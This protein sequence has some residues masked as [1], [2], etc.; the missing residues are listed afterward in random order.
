M[1]ER[2][3]VI[4]QNADVIAITYT[5]FVRV[6]DRKQRVNSNLN[7]EHSPVSV[8]EKTKAILPCVF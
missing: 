7:S 1:I 5:L 8:H 2:S 6:L 3:K 4:Y